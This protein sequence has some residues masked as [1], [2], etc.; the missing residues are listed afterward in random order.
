MRLLHPLN[1]GG[2]QERNGLEMPHERR[3][4]GGLGLADQCAWE[5]GT[6]WGLASCTYPKFEEGFSLASQDSFGDYTC[7]LFS[8]LTLA[9][10]GVG[11]GSHSHSTITWCREKHCSKKTLS[12]TTGR[13]G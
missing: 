1:Q 12:Q 11:A 8:P 6:R 7:Q 10:D 4:G 3:L 9:R 13:T 5:E 2:F